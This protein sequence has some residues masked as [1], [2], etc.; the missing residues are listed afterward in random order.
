[1]GF[2]PEQKALNDLTTEVGSLSKIDKL[3]LENRHQKIINIILQ[4]LEL[5]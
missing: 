4:D 5:L 1:M 2:T 3:F